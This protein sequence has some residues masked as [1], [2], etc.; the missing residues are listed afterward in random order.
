MNYPVGSKIRPGFEPA[1]DFFDLDPFHALVAR[2]L[3]SQIHRMLLMIYLPLVLTED[4]G[5]V[6]MP[7]RF[8]NDDIIH[9]E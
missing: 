3:A 9:I 8:S 1:F 6:G 5:P 7:Q 4:H 2:N